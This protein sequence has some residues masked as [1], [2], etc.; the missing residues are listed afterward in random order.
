M[1]G[2]TQ[3]WATGKGPQLKVKLHYAGNLTLFMGVFT[4][5]EIGKHY[6][7]GLNLLC[8]LMSALKTEVAYVKNSD[9][10]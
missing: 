3:W 2:S 5:T 7:I 6:K 9:L 1:G 4:P 8:N 10:S